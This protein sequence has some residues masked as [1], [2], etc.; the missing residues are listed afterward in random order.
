MRMHHTG[1]F[2]AGAPPANPLPA[3]GVAQPAKQAFA[4]TGTRF[5]LFCSSC[6]LFFC[7]SLLRFQPVTQELA[8]FL[9]LATHQPFQVQNTRPTLLLVPRWP[10]PPV[11]PAPLRQRKLQQP[12]QAQS[13]HL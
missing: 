5:W 13:D 9:P 11:V 6:T 1:S 4:A 7:L 3:E 2:V 8:E 12:Q 10:Q